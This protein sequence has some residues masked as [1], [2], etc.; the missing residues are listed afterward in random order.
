MPLKNRDR[1]HW[2]I[3]QAHAKPSE[4]PSAPAQSRAGDIDQRAIA[5]ILGSVDIQLMRT[6]SDQVIAKLQPSMVS[7]ARWEH[8]I[9]GQL[10]VQSEF[11]IQWERDCSV[12]IKVHQE[13]FDGRGKCRE[14]L[15]EMILLVAIHAHGPARDRARDAGHGS[16]V[17]DGSALQLIVG[18]SIDPLGHADR[19]QRI[20]AEIPNDGK[21]AVQ[22]CL[23]VNGFRRARRQLRAVAAVLPE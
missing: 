18:S 9:V 23:Q 7:A 11:R 20:R 22:S 15:A 13:T 6:E 19:R 5:R 14:V 3:A 2:R 1:G 12:E 4:I 17:A 10:A 21:R 8:R 16:R